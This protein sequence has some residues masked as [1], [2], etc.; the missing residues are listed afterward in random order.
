METP[1]WWYISAQNSTSRVYVVKN[2]KPGRSKRTDCTALGWTSD[3]CKT[4]SCTLI[5]DI[6]LQSSLDAVQGQLPENPQ[7]TYA[8]LVSQ[9]EHHAAKYTHECVQQVK[10][11]LRGPPS[12]RCP[13]LNPAKLDQADHRKDSVDHRQRHEHVLLP[14]RIAINVFPPRRELLKCRRTLLQDKVIDPH[15]F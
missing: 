1:T 2:S 6:G 12:N 9:S 4:T 10:H 13:Y 15:P 8:H 3:T 5:A 7:S 11:F 14:L